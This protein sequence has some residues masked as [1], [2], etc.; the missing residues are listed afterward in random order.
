M[1]RALPLQSMVEAIFGGEESD[2][3]NRRISF[4]L[5]EHREEW[6]TLL[7]IGW[8]LKVLIRLRCTKQLRT[9]VMPLI[10]N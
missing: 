1:M 7:T 8:N 6:G 3:H 5:K 10:Y 9:E 4:R 2:G